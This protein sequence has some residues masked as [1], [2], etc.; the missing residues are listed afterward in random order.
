[1]IGFVNEPGWEME[2]WGG[3]EN[4]MMVGR[5]TPCAPGIMGASLWPHF[6]TLH[7]K[8]FICFDESS[9]SSFS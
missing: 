4:Q 5:V 6:F 9:S 1:M 2:D 3:V 7:S 8:F